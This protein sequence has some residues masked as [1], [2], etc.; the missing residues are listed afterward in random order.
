MTHT[1]LELAIMNELIFVKDSNQA[2]SLSRLYALK[3]V[4][5]IYRGIYTDNWKDGLEAI[6]LRYWSEIVAHIVPGG[7]LSFRTAMDLNPAPI[8]SEMVVFITSTYVKTIQLPGLII[9]VLRGNNQDFVEPL[10][11]YINRSNTVRG[12][13]ENLSIAKGVYKNVK[14]IGIEGVETFLAKELNARGERVINAYRDEA[15]E[16]AMVLGYEKEF[17]LLN[18]IISALLVTHPDNSLLKTRYGQAVAKKEPFDRRRIALFEALSIFLNK[19]NFI[20][21]QYDYSK[22]SFR[23]LSFFE[24]YFSNFIEGTEFE[25]DEAENIVFQGIEVGNR[26]AD[27]HD[28]LANFNITNDYTEMHLTAKNPAEL[29][30]L[31]QN[32]HAYLMRERPEKNPGV[33]KRKPNRAGNTQFVLPGEVIGTLTH[34]FE[35]YELLQNGMAKALFMHLLISEVHP[36]DDGNGRLARIMM[37]AELVQADLYKIIMPTVM[38]DNYLSGLR[39]ASRDHDFRIYCKVL[40]Q[41]QAYTATCNWTDYE[42]AREKIEKDSAN[43]SS[44]EGLPLFNRTLRT[45]NLSQIGR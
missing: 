7:I 31:L 22:I 24:A 29:L 44:D 35:Y 10:F 19:C 9:K 43:L 8:R 39:L 41:A 30:T 42:E 20:S 28:V 37:N 34:G 17:Q 21:R 38:R 27:S 15:K 3:K 6:V 16:A 4:R 32:R 23:N 2:K 1:I 40:D 12:L 11:P 25:I 18:Q 36:F 14:V 26:H 5:R 13:L 45:L 33:F